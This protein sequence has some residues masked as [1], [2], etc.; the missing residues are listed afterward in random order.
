MDPKA[1]IQFSLEQLREPCLFKRKFI[2]IEKDKLEITE[3]AT[4]QF[5]KQDF[6]SP[7]GQALAQGC[8]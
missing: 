6:S 4:V 7:S 2:S 8:G 1:F 3:E 5:L